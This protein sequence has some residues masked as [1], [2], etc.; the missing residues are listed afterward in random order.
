[1]VTINFLDGDHLVIEKDTVLNGYKKI[2]GE[3]EF[4]L[5]N[6][7]SDSIDGHNSKEAS[8]LSTVNPQIGILGFILSVDCFSIGPDTENNVVYL[9]TSVKSVENSNERQMFGFSSIKMN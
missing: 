1:L 5:K 2:E 7:F 8:K 3:N 4:Y 9:S 6:V